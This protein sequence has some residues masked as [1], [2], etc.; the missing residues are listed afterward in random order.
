MLQRKMAGQKIT[1]FAR[2]H[3]SFTRSL[4]SVVAKLEVSTAA[5]AIARSLKRFAIRK[6]DIAD[7]KEDGRT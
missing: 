2:M 7:K 5:I 4:M 6:L 1:H 3:L